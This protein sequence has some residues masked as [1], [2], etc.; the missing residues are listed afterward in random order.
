MGIKK[1]KVVA[2]LAAACFL[3]LAKAQIYRCAVESSQSTFCQINNQT[4]SATEPFKVSKN[5]TYTFLIITG[6][7]MTHLPTTMFSNYPNISSFSVSTTELREISPEAFTF[8]DNLQTIML[9]F[10]NVSIVKAGTFSNCKNLRTLHISGHINLSVIESQAFKGLVS[11]THLYLNDDSFET[12]PSDVFAPLTR[13][14]FLSMSDNKLTSLNGNIFMN[15]PFLRALSIDN[16]LLTEIP[17]NIFQSQG[18]LSTLLVTFNKLT[19]AQTFGAEYFEG[20]NNLLNSI[21]ITGNTSTVMTNNN[22][23]RRINCAGSTFSTKIFYARNNSLNNIQCIRNMI[24]LTNLDLSQNSLNRPTPKMFTKLTKLRLLMLHNQ[25]KP[26]KIGP[27]ALAPLK[28][29]TNL[30][31]DNFISYRAIKQHLPS[32]FLIS[33]STRTWSCNLTKTVVDT[34]TTQKIRMNYIDHRDR[35]ICNITQPSVL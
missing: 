29:L 4:I 10:G 28:N 31:I 34:L 33:F 14:L 17:G 21:N 5:G 3:S 13:L 18:T 19:S 16:N 1:F 9:R 26:W 20:S 12:L 8:C 6:G 23:L 35:F 30:Q 2:F 11:L 25:T 7:S 32:L 22:L 24:N 27:R 15:N